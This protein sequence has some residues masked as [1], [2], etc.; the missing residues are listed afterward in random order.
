VQPVG[1]LRP[2]RQQSTV[3]MVV[4]S[5]L[6]VMQGRLT[7]QCGLRR[8]L[9]RLKS[10]LFYACDWQSTKIQQFTQALDLYIRW[11]N[12]QLIKIS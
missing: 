8:L 11:Y 7:G 2:W 5:A 6:N 9:R 12:E 10:E 4:V 1:H 3:N